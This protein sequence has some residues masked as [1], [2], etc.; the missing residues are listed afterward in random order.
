MSYQRTDVK[1]G[2]VSDSLASSGHEEQP[3]STKQSGRR[4]MFVK[5]AILTATLVG[6]VLIGSA[7]SAYSEGWVEE[8]QTVNRNSQ[9]TPVATAP[10][11]GCNN[12]K[13]DDEADVWAKIKETSLGK[14]TISRISVFQI[15]VHVLILFHLT[16]SRTFEMA[17]L[18]L[19]MDAA[20][21]LET[22]CSRTSVEMLSTQLS[23]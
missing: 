9:N 12:D 17:P 22:A 13:Q 15:A 10:V 11:A 6:G 23:L 5:G 3:Q 16:Q 7:F 4:N 2:A 8:K 19:M 18:P 14:L 1:Y 20:R 21:T